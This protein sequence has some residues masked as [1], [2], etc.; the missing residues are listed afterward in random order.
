MC[1]ITCSEK[2]QL[3][4]VHSKYSSKIFQPQC[5]RF[6]DACLIWQNG[7]PSYF[8]LSYIVCWKWR[9]WNSM[10]YFFANLHLHYFLFGPWKIITLKALPLVL[11]FK[12]I[13]C[14]ILLCIRKTA[15]RNVYKIAGE[16]KAL[17]VRSQEQLSNCLAKSSLTTYLGHSEQII[18]LFFCNFVTS[19]IRI[20]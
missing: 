18:I 10:L 5:K 15:K 6:L 9:Y 13:S 17:W 11:N 4:N 14:N 2:F 12:V 16:N 3:G 19:I 8:W 20:I 7:L 1:K